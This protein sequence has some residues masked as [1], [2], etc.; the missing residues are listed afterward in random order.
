[1][2]AN[3]MNLWP[4]VGLFLAGGA[5]YCGIVAPRSLLALGQ[6]ADLIVVGAASGASQG[7]TTTAFSLQ[8][9]RVVKGD[10]ALAGSEIAASWTSASLSVAGAPSFVGGSGV[11]F[12]QQSSGAWQVLPVLQGAAHLSDTFFPAP[13]GPILSAYAYGLAASLSDKLASEMSSATEGANSYNFQLYALQYG[14]LDQL[15]SPTV[16]VLYQRMSASASPQQ[17]ALGLG[18]LIRGGSAAALASAAQ[19]AATLASYQVENGIL[20]LSIRDYF[21]AADAN[22]VAAAGSATVGSAGLSLA[23]REA[24]A[25]ALAAIHTAAAL[26]YLAALLDDPDPNL[27]AEAIGG[28]GAF[29]NGLPVQTSAGTPSLAYLQLPA[30]A[31]YKTADTIANLAFGTQAITRNEASYLSFWTSWWG[32]NRAGLGY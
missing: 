10:Q 1:M 19:A 8:V 22:S 23:F 17:Q 14:L 3:R 12:L 15:Q 6:S 21:R 28:M 32:Q 9:S 26:P 13:P 4:I 31:P 5:G 18:G 2:D 30:S 25:H 7:G 24:A 11:W 29:A 20:L 16:A 27:R